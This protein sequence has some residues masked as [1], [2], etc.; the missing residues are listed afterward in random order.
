MLVGKPLRQ[1]AVSRLDGIHDLLVLLV[2]FR[3]SVGICQRLPPHPQ[4]ILMKILQLMLQQLAVTGLIH[5]VMKTVV[6]LRKLF[7]MP[8]A[9][10]ELSQI[11]IFFH[12]FHLFL[13]DMLCG[14]SGTK[15][16]Q[17]GT[18]HID[19]LYIL[20]RNTG[21]I[22][23]FIGYDLDQPLQLQL[24]ECFS[25]RRAADSHL[26]PDGHFPQFFMLRVSAV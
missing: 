7:Q 14:P 17:Q 1:V 21:N 22:S 8:L 9:G 26:L 5:D 20:F 18:D 25:Y 12:L 24:P 4:H 3:P 13:R 15:P 11:Y 2:G 6:Q 16:F 23:A 19:I 10:M